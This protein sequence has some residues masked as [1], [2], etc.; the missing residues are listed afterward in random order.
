MEKCSRLWVLSALLGGD[1]KI[2]LGADLR[3]SS[4]M[5]LLFGTFF[6]LFGLADF[7]EVCH[8]TNKCSEG[9]GWVFMFLMGM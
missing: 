5:L 1:R 6:C 4:T 3:E 8:G 9:T 7:S 2:G